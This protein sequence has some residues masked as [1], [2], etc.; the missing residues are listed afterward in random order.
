MKAEEYVEY[1]REKGT[2]IIET[3]GIYWSRAR[4]FFYENIPV[5]IPV[6]ASPSQLVRVILKG[7]YLAVLMHSR[8]RANRLT[9]KSVCDDPDYD[10]EKL[11]L[12]ARKNVRR[13]LR[14]CSV[15]QIDLDFLARE[16]NGINRSALTR[17]G[18][19]SSGD[20]GTPS[21]WRRKM[22]TC[23]RYDDIQAWGAF[24]DNSLAAYALCIVIEDY[25]EINNFM[26]HTRFLS[27]YP[28]RALM[29]T[30]TREMLGRQGI[31]RV[32][33][34]T[35]GNLASVADFKDRMGYRRAPFPF[36]LMVNPLARPLLSRFAKFRY[37]DRTCR[38]NYLK[39]TDR[40]KSSGDSEEVSGIE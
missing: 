31:K 28:G 8:N 4:P 38:M 22:D 6:D 40:I 15:R 36:R 18:R 14:N 19:S 5:L 20:M 10:L 17:Q 2:K 32:E 29:Y 39:Y 1:N 11:S 7:S 13:G 34:G 33:V 23:K 16:G 25:C 35:S 26:S 27:H 12:N 9:F 37:Y 21:K 24:V 3:D 30:V